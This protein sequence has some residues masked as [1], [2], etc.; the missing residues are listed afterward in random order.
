MRPRGKKQSPLAR[1]K[2]E[3]LR[4]VS[5]SID[6]RKPEFILRPRSRAKFEEE[7]TLPHWK[8]KP[9]SSVLRLKKLL[10]KTGEMVI[11]D[12]GAEKNWHYRSSQHEA[13]YRWTLDEEKE[14][15]HYVREVL[16]EPNR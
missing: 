2:S 14:L 9:I 15:A 1:S 3:T 10:L 7:R 12:Q 13:K 4:N 6:W 8:N 5:I 11:N 16:L